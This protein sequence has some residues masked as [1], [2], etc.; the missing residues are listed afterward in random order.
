MQTG[1][2][3]GDKIDRGHMNYQDAEAI[4]DQHMGNVLGKKGVMAKLSPTSKKLDRCA[5]LH[6]KDIDFNGVIQTFYTITLFR[7]VDKSD[8]SIREGNTIL[9][10]HP[11]Y[12]TM[13]DRGWFSKTTHSKLNEYAPRGFRIWGQRYPYLP[14]EVRPI[15]FIKTPQGVYPYCMPFQTDYEGRP[16]TTLNTMQVEK[17]LGPTDVAD[18]VIEALPEYVNTY[19]KHLLAGTIPYSNKAC[20]WIKQATAHNA[21]HT[22]KEIGEI[23]LSKRFTAELASTVVEFSNDGYAGLTVQEIVDILKVEG[24]AA[25]KRAN[26]NNKAAH[27]TERVLLHGMPMPVIPSTWI[28]TKLRPLIHEH[29]IGLLT[30]DEVHWNRKDQQ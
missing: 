11:D 30:F 13:D 26:T 7:K 19:L 9:T 5:W 17:S 10:M 14:G 23:I 20:W 16:L 24:H 18:K 27:R 21:Q 1:L 4:M 8:G 29:L 15:G 25:F 22:S 3:E 12:V 2:V 28:T 6:R